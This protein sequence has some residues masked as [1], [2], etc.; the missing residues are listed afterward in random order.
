[1]LTTFSQKAQCSGTDRI[2]ARKSIQPLNHNGNS[3]EQKKYTAPI[4]V[5]ANEHL[6]VALFTFIGCAIGIGLMATTAFLSHS[7]PRTAFRYTT[8]SSGS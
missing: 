4:R 5:G 7:E 8:H 3:K 2:P 1:M 6:P